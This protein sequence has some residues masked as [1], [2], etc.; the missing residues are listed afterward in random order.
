LL[1]ACFASTT[2]G[3]RISKKAAVAVD[4]QEPTVAELQQQLDDARRESALAQ[5][6]LRNRRA[7]DGDG[8]INLKGADA[9]RIVNMV[10]DNIRLGDD[11]K[12]PLIP[13]L[14]PKPGQVFEV[15][16]REALDFIESNAYHWN[17]VSINENGRVV[18][19]D[20]W[21]A[22]IDGSFFGNT[23][24]WKT[25]HVMNNR[26]ERLFTIHMTKHMWNPTRW[27]WSFRIAHP[28]TDKVLFTINKDW[29]G[30]GWF[31][32]RDE[33]RVYRGHKGD[34]DQVYY[35][36]SSYIGYE[37]WC[38]ANKHEWNNGREPRAT[39]SQSMARDL[40][41]LPDK[42]SLTV[43]EGEDTGLLLATTVIMDMVYEQEEAN[44]RAADMNEERRRQ[45]EQKRRHGGSHP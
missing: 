5:A 25:T 32:M 37:H 19:P 45:Q 33:W 11:P 38:Y 4:A 44:E 29:F 26:R 8:D 41:G 6:E 18:Y 40:I 1:L 12:G 36:V 2:E 17:M 3:R 15:M 34:N 35:C 22:E 27:T 39:F 43:R 24:G 42:S 13:A 7:S 20:K 31:M 30:G 28:V 14:V 9:D 10:L 16:N 21:F 23:M